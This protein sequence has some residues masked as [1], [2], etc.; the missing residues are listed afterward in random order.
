M[1]LG[2]L[3][4]STN[5][6]RE[7]LREEPE[8]SVLIV[9]DSPAAPF[10]VPPK[11]VDY[12][13]LPTIVKTGDSSWAPSSLSISLEDTLKLRSRLIVKAYQKFRPDVILV[14]HMPVGALGELKPLIDEAMSD[15]TPPRL[16][17]GLRDVLDRPEVIQKAWQAAGGYDYLKFYEAVLIYGTSELHDS[18]SI[19]DLRS[20]SK[21]VIFC[22]YVSLDP[23]G[24]SQVARSGVTPSADEV[25]LVLVMGGGGADLFPLAK[26]FIEAVPH[27][28]PEMP[29]EAVVLPGPN[30]PHD[31]MVTLGLMAE[32]QPVDVQRGFE[33]ATYWLQRASAVVMMAGYKSVCEVMA[34]Q[35]KALVVPRPGP[36][37]EQRIRS[38]LFAQRRLIHMIDPDEL[39]P[40]RRAR[41]VF[42]LLVDDAVPNRE[43]MPALDGARR[44][45]EALLA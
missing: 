27:L 44:A 3:R 15:T 26:T 34:W 33:D 1:G 13:K 7:I 22:N 25:P 42:E 2:H 18:A 16:F 36:S 38:Q 8:A 31:D 10:F 41:G 4:R 14:D 24:G 43:A 9:A 5:I 28:Q 32:S 35:K 6:A 11:G 19:Y 23:S 39:T 21:D 45:A 12:L 17:L 30:I 20:R 40:S 29:M 37:A